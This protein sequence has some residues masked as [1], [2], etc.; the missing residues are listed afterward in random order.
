MAAED[1]LSMFYRSVILFIIFQGSR[2]ARMCFPWGRV[3][4][5]MDYVIQSINNM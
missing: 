5:F 3:W 2:N 1:K 4:Q